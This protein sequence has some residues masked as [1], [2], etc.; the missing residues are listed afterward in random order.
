M[1]RQE[2]LCFCLGCGFV[3]WLVCFLLFLFV[4]FSWGVFVW[5]L[6][7]GFSCVF[8]LLLLLLFCC[9]CC[10]P[11][12]EI[13][14]IRGMTE[15]MSGDLYVCVW[16]GREVVCLFFPLKAEMGETKRLL[17]C[18]PRGTILTRTADL[19]MRTRR[20]M[21]PVLSIQNYETFCLE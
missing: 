21:S 14:A 8:L 9:C 3:G 10:P 4:S 16:R 15:V 20:L 13:D 17:F 2:F 7:W 1:G 6:F 12:A 5:V 18:L 11:Y 19:V